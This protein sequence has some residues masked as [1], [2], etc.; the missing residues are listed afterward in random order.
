MN[1]DFSQYHPLDHSLSECRGYPGGRRR[2]LS[3]LW[4]FRWREQ[5]EVWLRHT[6]G[7]HTWF[8][9]VR[10]SGDEPVYRVACRGCNA[11]PDPASV[12]RVIGNMR[13]DKQFQ[14]AIR[15]LPLMS[16]TFDELEDGH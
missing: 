15:A 2:H 4:E 11:T 14:S 3:Y 16:D 13:N 10:V 12:A 9:M 7:R 1:L 5:L 6:S 8:G